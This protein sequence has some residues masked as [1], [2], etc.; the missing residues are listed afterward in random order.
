VNPVVKI[1]VMNGNTEEA[2]FTFDS[3][4]ICKVG[5]DRDCEIRF[6]EV[7]ENGDVPESTFYRALVRNRAKL[8]YEKIGDW[9]DSDRDPPEDLQRLP[10]LKAQIELQ[11][12]AAKRLAA[13]RRSKGALEFESIQSSAVVEGG[14]I[15]RRVS[16]HSHSARKMIENFIVS[17]NFDM[18]RFLEDHGSDSLWT[19]PRTAKI[20]NSWDSPPIVKV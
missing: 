5:R 15:K 19:A 6:A 1:R 18:A 3:P 9:L 2:C 11:R 4:T 20:G 12:E 7:K 16:G 17:S 10:D 14:E 13:Y 8:S